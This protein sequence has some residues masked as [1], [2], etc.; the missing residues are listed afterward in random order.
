MEYA[1][2]RRGDS[3]PS[4]RRSGF[5]SVTFALDFTAWE[6]TPE[7]EQAAPEAQGSQPG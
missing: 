2:R 3:E 7:C 4:L 1:T 6:F 5:F